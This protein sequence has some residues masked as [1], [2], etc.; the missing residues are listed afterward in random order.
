[1]KRLTETKR[2]K[3]RQGETY[4]T[5]K[6]IDKKKTPKD[7]KRHKETLRDKKRQKQTKRDKDIQRQKTDIKRHE[8]T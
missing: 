1:M 5:Q 8:E 6:D 7:M 2:E 3:N 4:P